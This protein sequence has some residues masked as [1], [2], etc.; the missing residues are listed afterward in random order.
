MPLIALLKVA[1][2]KGGEIKGAHISKAA[3]SSQGATDGV[4]SGEVPVLA[5]EH[6]VESQ[7]DP[8]SGQRLDERTFQPFV[9]TKLVDHSSPAFHKALATGDVFK[10]WKLNF[11]AMAEGEPKTYLT[12]VLGGARIVSIRTVMPDLT[13]PANAN[14]HEYEEI[15]FQYDDIGWGDNG[16][17][18][19]RD[20]GVNPGEDWAEAQARA[21]LLTLPGM[22]ETEL[23]TV[24]DLLKQAGA[25]A[26]QNETETD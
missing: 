12:V 9:V 17:A 19:I 5:A 8:V 26:L 1:A 10:E 2:G 24:K 21:A 22:Y 7:I 14:V 20:T 25:E 23:A 6:R 4:M 15:A 13:I 18:A 3:G 11:K 16:T